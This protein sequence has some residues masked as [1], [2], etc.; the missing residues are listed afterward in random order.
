M[1][2]ERRKRRKNEN[3]RMG[4]GRNGLEGSRERCEVGKGGRKDQNN[5]EGTLTTDLFEQVHIIS[6]VASCRVMAKI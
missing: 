1:K 6:V 2:E 5:Y 4:S 3:D